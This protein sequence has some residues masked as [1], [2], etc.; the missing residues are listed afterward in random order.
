MEKVAELKGNDIDRS[1]RLVSYSPSGKLL[2][3]MDA[4]DDHNIAI[5][6]TES[7]ACVAK[8]KGDRSNILDMAWSSETEFASVGPKHFKLWTI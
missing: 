4:S 1:I 2:A 6:D 8:S 7:F 5:Y 3:V